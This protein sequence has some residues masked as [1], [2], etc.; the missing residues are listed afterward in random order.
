MFMRNKNHTIK[1]SEAILDGMSYALKNI[2]GTYIIG[3]GVPDPKAIFGTTKGLSKKFR[4]KKIF[5]MPVAEAGMT[6]IVIGSSINGLRPVMIH[7]RVDFML[8]SMDQLAN[9]AAKLSYIF[10]GQLSVPIVIRAV[11]GRGW[12]QSAQHSQTLESL[13]ANFPGLKVVSPS[14][15]IDARDLL[16]ASIYDNNPV[17]FLEH[18]W[19]HDTYSNFKPLKKISLNGPKKISN[20]RDITII[21]FS[22]SISEILKADKIL[23]KLDIKIEIIDLRIIRPLNLELIYESILKTKRVIVVDNG[24]SQYGVSS[25]IIASICERMGNKLLANPVRIGIEAHPTPSSKSLITN[26]YPSV[27]KIIMSVT[28]LLKLSDNKI[29]ELKYLLSEDSDDL[30]IDVPNQYFKGPF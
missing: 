7:Q 9:T 25:E 14:N 11:I 4:N 27:K 10:N 23:K 12:G 30:E 5:D 15:A 22:Y 8:I 18:R 13:F 26:Y 16:V 24:F 28:K 1:F 3:E 20:G 17:I 19:L 29:K 21:G 2:Q 6:G